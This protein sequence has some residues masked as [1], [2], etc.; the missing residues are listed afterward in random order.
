MK[1][2]YFELKT[3]RYSIKCK[4]FLPKGDVKQV[5]VGVHG[6][7]GDKESSA[8][9]ALAEAVSAHTALLCF[10]FPAHGEST[11]EDSQLRVDN[12]IEDLKA[13]FSFACERFVGL[14]VSVFATSF[15]GYISVLAVSRGEISP[16]N[17][18][19]RA[20]AVCM[21]KVLRKNLIGDGFEDFKRKGFLKFGFQ[22]KMVVPYEFYLDLAENDAMKASFDVPALMFCATRDELVEPEDL[23]AFAAEKDTVTVV[24]IDG[25][26]HRFKGEGELEVLIEKSK[27]FLI[28][29]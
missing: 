2:D 5:V 4:L 21:E 7:G 6:F 13:V 25:A 16:C 27:A 22:R 11:A 26:G 17:V 12:C 29:E 9:A 1:V 10:D 24:N 19:L 15:G 18:I 14:P 23:Y 8:L 3:Q 28:K 20:P